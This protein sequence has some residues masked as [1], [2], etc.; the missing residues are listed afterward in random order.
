MSQNDGNGGFGVFKSLLVLICSVEAFTGWMSPLSNGGES[1]EVDVD[2]AEGGECAE[3][4]GSS[5][6]R[7]S[8]TSRCWILSPTF[9][10]HFR[11]QTWNLHVWTTCHFWITIES[12]ESIEKFDRPLQIL[13]GDDWS[14]MKEPLLAL[15]TYQSSSNQNI[16]HEIQ[17]TFQFDDGL[18]KLKA[19]ESISCE[20]F[21]FVRNF[22]RNVIC[23]RGIL[24]P[25]SALYVC[26][27]EASSVAF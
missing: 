13:K 18:H 23:F 10:P 27:I 14:L 11:K 4:V 25:I 2:I 6:V 7:W 21:R 3:S 1:G 20:V 9:S 15:S 5:L 22:P 17:Y 16:Q 19:G 8:Q 26:L 12:F 24:L